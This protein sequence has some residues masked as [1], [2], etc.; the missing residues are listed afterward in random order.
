M[1]LSGVFLALL[2]LLGLGLG[3]I[4]RHTAGAIATFVGVTFLLPLLLSAV[5]G[6]PGRFTPGRSWPTPWRPW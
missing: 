4:I 2:A 1:V 6:N 3:L 5:P